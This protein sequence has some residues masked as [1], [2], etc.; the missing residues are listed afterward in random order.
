MGTGCG[1]ANGLQ[2]AA[3]LIA[4]ITITLWV[5]ANSILIFGLLK[6]SIGVRVEE[7]MEIEGLDA[8]EHGAIAYELNFFNNELMEQR[9][10]KRSAKPSTE[11]EAAPA[12]EEEEG[13]I[14]RV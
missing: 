13:A 12:A 7:K 1:N 6:V 10:I 8:S 14:M 4:A 3:Q 11:G 9:E 5:A 2:F